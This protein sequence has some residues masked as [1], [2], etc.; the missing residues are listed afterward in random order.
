MR[1]DL[2][3]FQYTSFFFSFLFL[4]LASDD[5]IHVPIHSVLVGD[6]WLY[7]IDNQGWVFLLDALRKFNPSCGFMYVTLSIVHHSMV[8]HTCLWSL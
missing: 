7:S 5:S 8:F 3:P 1:M 2:F 6:G 4:H